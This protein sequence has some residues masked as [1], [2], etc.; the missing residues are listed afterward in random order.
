[1][2]TIGPDEIDARSFH[3][4]P[5]D[6]V[7]VALTGL[8]PE[9]VWITRLEA[10][11]PQAALAQDMGLQAEAAQAELHNWVSATEVV[12]PPCADWEPGIAPV[13]GTPRQP[14]PPGGTHRDLIVFGIVLAAL[15][16][17]FARRLA[18]PAPVRAALAR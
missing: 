16:S 15:A 12:N 11:L 7:G 6:D 4:G 14:P 1:M 17:A 3:C 9:G 2:G 13:R 5:L 8:H 18:R 10:N